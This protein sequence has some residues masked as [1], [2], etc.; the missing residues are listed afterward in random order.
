MSYPGHSIRLLQPL[1]VGRFAPLQK[2]YG[3]AVVQHMKDTRTGIA[4]GAFW[5]FYQEA[6]AVSYTLANI[7]SAWRATSIVPYNPDALLTQLPSYKASRARPVPKVSTT[8][9]VFKFLKTPANRRELRQQTLSA[10]EYTGSDPA[11]F[12]VA[13]QSSIS[14]FRR[15]AYQ[16]EAALT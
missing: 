11:I 10:V 14:L 8:P 3:D 7:K 6:Q 9:Q 5:A 2:A 15:L 1:D 4:K 16:T 12:D 13:K